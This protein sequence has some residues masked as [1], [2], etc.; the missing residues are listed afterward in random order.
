M[1]RNLA[2]THS[3]AVVSIILHITNRPPEVFCVFQLLDKLKRI[4]KSLNQ[5]KFIMYIVAKNPPP[6]HA[7]HNRPQ[8]MVMPFVTFSFE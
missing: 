3:Q 4:Y 8:M 2:T 1:T 6:G 5:L 7:I